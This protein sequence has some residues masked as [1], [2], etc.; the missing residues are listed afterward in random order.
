MRRARSRRSRTGG[1]T[2]TL[3]RWR[4]TSTTSERATRPLPSTNARFIS[5]ADQRASSRKGRGGGTPWSLLLH[6]TLRHDTATMTS[7]D[8]IYLNGPDV[9][10]LALTDDEILDA[11]ESGL[12]APG[13][14]QTVI[15][16]RVH[17]VPESSAKGHFNVLR[18]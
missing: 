5:R 12:R 1:A 14:G 18:G 6:L 17:L 11:V 16:P 7:I 10:A 4:A 3:T 8:F 13:L 15:E 2:V 9:E